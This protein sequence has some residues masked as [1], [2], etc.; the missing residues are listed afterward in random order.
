MMNERQVAVQEPEQEAAADDALFSE[1]DAGSLRQRWES[2]QAG[3]VDEPRRAVEEA[4]K[5]VADAIG[6]LTEDF[7]RERARLEQ[8]WTRGDDAS[9]EDLRIAFQRYRSF[10]Q[11]L[12]SA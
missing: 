6:K 3:F 5:L 9:T 11:R 10:F 7:A 8:Q 1:T 12:L 2:V 4:D